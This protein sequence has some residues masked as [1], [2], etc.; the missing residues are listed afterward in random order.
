MVAHAESRGTTLDAINGGRGKAQRDVAADK[1]RGSGH[2]RQ[3]QSPI[4]N[5]RS[6]A[7]P[8]E[9][10]GEMS[11]RTSIISSDYIK[12]KGRYQFTQHLYLS[13]M[14]FLEPLFSQ[15]VKLVKQCIWRCF[16]VSKDSAGSTL[17]LA[18]SG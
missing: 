11:D 4:G 7:D 18:D 3:L 14:N 13:L 15:M 12:Y 16:L 6:Q 1:R 17:E 10:G 2:L 9:K 5:L 8:A